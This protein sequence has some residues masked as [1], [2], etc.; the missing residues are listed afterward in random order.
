[1]RNWLKTVLFVSSYSPA[2]LV[3]GGVRWYSIGEIDALV[4]QLVIISILGVV[5]PL[6]ILALLRAEAESINFKA[7]K[8]ESTDYFLLVFVASY[9]APIAMKV[10]EVNFEMI[11]LFVCVVFV[12]G[13]LVS[14]IPCHP[15]LYLFK[16]RFYKIESDDGMV[17]TLITRRQ[18]RSPKN[19]KSVKKISS[20]MLME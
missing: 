10:A 2:L 13:W 1:M 19:I 9:L 15:V 16:F 5:L 8:V 20:G 14:N 12:L 4:V 18:I 6:L 3:L 17:Y 11:F 7:K